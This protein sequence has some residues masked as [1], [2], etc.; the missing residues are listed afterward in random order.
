L[1]DITQAI[2]TT[3]DSERVLHLLLEKITQLLPYSVAMLSLYNEEL[4]RLEHVAFHDSTG[5]EW[6][7]E[8]GKK[9]GKGGNNYSDIVFA[10][11][12]PV[13]VEEFATDPRTI[14]VE[15]VRRHGLVSYVGIPLQIMG[16]PLGVLGFCT[17]EKRIFAKEEIEFLT[18]LAGQAA[19]AINNSKLFEQYRQKTDELKSANRRLSA[20]YEVTAT[21]GE[22]LD[23]DPVLRQVV[24][25]VTRIFGFDATRVLLLDR[26]S[27][28]ARLRCSFARRPELWTQART[29]RRGEGNVG[30]VI[31][32]NEPIIFDDTDADPR[33]K[34]QSKTKLSLRNRHRFLAVFPI[35]DKV[36]TLG[37]LVCAGVQPR[38]LSPD[39]TELL[40][41]M[42]RQ[43]GIAI[44]NVRLFEDT[45]EKAN[46]LERL[47]LELALAEER[48]RR[49]LAEGLHDDVGQ[50]LA[51]VQ[52]KLGEL[53]Q[54]ET[55]KQ[56][57]ASLKGLRKL[58]DQTIQTTRSLTFDLSSPIL[59]SL[60]L[61]A[62]LENL[63]ER[64]EAERGIAVNFRSDGEPKPLREEVQIILYRSVRELLLN[65]AKHAQAKS[66]TLVVERRGDTICI[67]VEDEGIGF[68]RSPGD[69]QF[70]TDQKLGLFSVGEQLKKIGG[71]LR[72]EPRSGAGTKATLTAPILAS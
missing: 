72:I 61:E 17:K 14:D 37:T 27:Q 49:R 63:S 22:S 58:I 25:H 47:T 46:E 35:S 34:Q 50:N 10:G 28:E 30:R 66:V 32:T 69:Q 70:L 18:I 52:L 16:N 11:R 64:L 29:F 12:K 48:E 44:S 45:C 67:C 1:Y 20:L 33:Y 9:V 65:V 15:F 41:T 42:T 21:V 6:I 8:K 56:N 13:V 2:T 53:L 7:K 26:Q 38:H 59:Y 68:K 40:M 31:E 5:A 51:T 55:S 19:I 23:L 43:I 62:A 60:G 4:C 54:A 24:D 71:E 36:S 57:K 39:E 3:V